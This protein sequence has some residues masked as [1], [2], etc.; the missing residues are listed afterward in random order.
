[1]P[2]KSIAVY[3]VIFVMF[4]LSFLLKALSSSLPANYFFNLE[5][6]YY[7]TIICLVFFTVTRFEQED[8]KSLG[9]DFHSPGPKI[10][11]G[12]V[13]FAVWS[14]FT[15]IP[16]L[17]GIN[18]NVLFSFRPSSLSVL[19]LFT[20]YD[21]IFVSF[22]EELVFRGFLLSR[23]EQITNSRVIAVIVSSVL[24]GLWHYPLNMDIVQVFTA[25]FIGLIFCT[26]KLKSKSQ[27]ITPLI[28]AHGLNDAFLL[29]LAFFIR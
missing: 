9:L 18:K 17:F 29:W 27:S 6:L 24:F 28:I 16:L 10:W 12:L 11:L 3:L 14:L 19:L 21:L 20:I 25:I 1:L 23:I 13:I 7:V 8:L 2:R 5:I 15:V 26:I 4:L 22:G